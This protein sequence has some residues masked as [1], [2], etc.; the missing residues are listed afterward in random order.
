MRLN[1]RGL[2]LT[3][4]LALATASPWVSSAL[5][6]PVA[7]AQTSL[8][9]VTSQTDAQS[10][11]IGHLT[12]FGTTDPSKH[13]LPENLAKVFSQFLSADG[14]VPF[15]CHT[16]D[17]LG[18][19]NVNCL[20]TSAS[21]IA[22]ES[23]TALLVDVGTLGQPVL[24]NGQVGLGIRQAT[25]DANTAIADLTDV[26][27]ALSVAEGLVVL[28]GISIGATHSAATP[29]SATADTGITVAKIEVFPI[30]ALLSLVGE[31]LADLS[32]SALVELGDSLLPPDS[33]DALAGAI[34]TFEQADAET[35]QDQ[36][37]LDAA[38]AELTD[39]DVDLAAD[40]AAIAQ[41]SSLAVK[42]G[43]S[44]SG[45][46][47][48][49]ATLISL[50]VQSAKAAAT[51]QLDLT[52]GAFA[53]TI[54]AL[55][56]ITFENLTIQTSALADESGAEPMA[57]IQWGSAT[58]AGVA[59]PVGWTLQSLVAAL[60]AASTAVGNAIGS[61]LGISFDMPQPTT[62]SGMNGD[63]RA[64]S[65]GLTA[66]SIGF[67]EFSAQVLSMS[68]EAEYRP[69]VETS[70]TPLLGPGPGPGPVS[71]PPPPLGATGDT[72][73]TPLGA[74]MLWA[75]VCLMWF[76]RFTATGR[77]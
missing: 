75:A 15:D 55:P 13:A 76:L 47:L 45:T 41:V 18:D 10:L 52:R 4:T 57:S 27:A 77:R 42:Y 9:L 3:L 11:E 60:D 40:L 5:I 14:L 74:A 65:A 23:G 28:E 43:L 21:G 44:C 22:N 33:T 12:G 46:P 35:D 20:E 69:G 38:V 1:K 6:N 70:S 25:T 59:L 30:D 49:C 72:S 71:A 67:S 19:L 56:L 63:Y 48:E 31:T 62:S 2:T 16:L 39:G 64:S 32:A 7:S 34:Q 29:T 66:F 68:A 73:V 50:A 51:G 53:A 58:V 37:L 36:A 54:G 61:A 26:F 24:V 17:A 8:T